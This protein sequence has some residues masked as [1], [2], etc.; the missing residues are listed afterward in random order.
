MF[1]LVQKLPDQLLEKYA[2]WLLGFTFLCMFLVLIPGVGEIKYGARRWIRFFSIGFQPSELLKVA[3]VVW[4]ADFLKRKKAKLQSL[5]SGVLPLVVLIALSAVLLL[6][7]PDFGT[8]ILITTTMFCMAYYAGTRLKDIAILFFLVVLASIVAIFTNPYRLTRL[9][10]YLDPWADPTDTGFQLI[11]SILAFANGGIF[12]Q[13]LGNS[14]QKQYFLPFPQTDFIF[15]TLGE[16]L[17]LIGVSALLLLFFSLLYSGFK[18]ANQCKDDFAKYFC[19]GITILIV[20]QA[21]LHFGV[22]LGILPTKGIGLPFISYGGSSLLVYS[23][24]VAWVYKL[25]KKS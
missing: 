12:G 21:F 3:L 11:N 1:G 16:E 6:L 22:V 24:A 9:N 20:L 23:F 17:G 15:A 5:P 8:I 14:L 25:T 2:F 7:Q 19:L 18:L 10:A 13:G 4:C